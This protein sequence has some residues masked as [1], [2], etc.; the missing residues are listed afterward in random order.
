MGH[1]LLTPDLEHED[2]EA[3]VLIVV[4]AFPGSVLVLVWHLASLHK[5]W[6][7]ELLHVGCLLDILD[8]SGILLIFRE[9][10]KFPFLKVR[11]PVFVI[12]TEKKA[13]NP[14]HEY[15]EES[16]EKILLSI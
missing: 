5:C 16:E 3:W 9:W 10:V 7:N 13:E 6:L 8:D 15:L 2:L 14:L 4:S 12:M 11:N 1:S